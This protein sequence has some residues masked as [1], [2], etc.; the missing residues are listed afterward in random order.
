MKPNLLVIADGGFTYEKLPAILRGAG[1]PIGAVQSI[2]DG[3]SWLE[4]SGVDV[5]ILDEAAL[6]AELKPTLQSFRALR[7]GLEVIVVLPEKSTG[8]SSKLMSEGV[9][10]CVPESFPPESLAV[11]LL[12]SMENRLLRAR[13]SDSERQ[14]RGALGVRSGFLTTLSY[15]IKAPMTAIAGATKMLMGRGMT[16]KPGPLQVAKNAE[17]V[18]MIKRNSDRILGF[19]GEVLE[20][21][22]IR[23][24]DVKPDV[25]AIAPSAFLDEAFRGIQKILEELQVPVSRKPNVVA[26]D[27]DLMKM[28]IGCDREQMLKVMLQLSLLFARANP[29]PQAVSIGLCVE[30]DLT[31][32]VFV[33]ESGSG[34]VEPQEL[35]NMFDMFRDLGVD[36]GH[37]D[38]Y[39]FT[40]IL[41]KQ[42]VELNGG[43][44]WGESEGPGKALR[45]VV[46]LPAKVG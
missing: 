9:G 13:L 29:K 35:A 21:E 15:E 27:V 4:G 40:L 36:E 39:G 22:R 7:P 25:K 16:E 28:A 3:R 38:A 6:P 18:E 23:R 17:L 32:V 2:Q 30:A 20:L 10:L 43:K 44:I 45:Y 26:P 1:F 41:C 14:S 8:R 11:I 33:L 19:L 34:G 42:L 31:G 5:L 37:K 24:G 46:S 12:Q